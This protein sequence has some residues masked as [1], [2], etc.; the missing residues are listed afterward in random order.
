MGGPYEG[1]KMVG[2]SLAVGSE[3]VLA[4]GN[5]NEFAGELVVAA[6]NVP[7]PSPYWYGG[8]QAYKDCRRTPKILNKK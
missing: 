4:R 7:L 8:E 3:G 6:F 2:C 1:K 5:Y